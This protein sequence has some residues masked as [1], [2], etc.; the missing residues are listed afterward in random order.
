LLNCRY[1][2]A[3]PFSPLIPV[4]VQSDLWK[5]VSPFNFFAM[6]GGANVAEINFPSITRVSSG[7]HI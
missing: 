3:G 1:S 5:V 6:G 2:V 7:Y 4:H